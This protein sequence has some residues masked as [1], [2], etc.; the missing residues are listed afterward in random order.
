MCSVRLVLG[1]ERLGE[2]DDGALPPLRTLCRALDMRTHWSASEATFYIESPATGRNVA[3]V[4]EPSNLAVY[5]GAADQIVAMLKERLAQAGAQ[6]CDNPQE[7]HLTLRIAVG[8]HTAAGV[9]AT[10]P[11]STRQSLRTLAG[12]ITAEVA[13]EAQLADLG[14]KASLIGGRSLPAPWLQV[15][16][17]RPDQENAVRLQDPAVCQSVA[18]GIFGGLCRHWAG[19]VLTEICRYLPDS[20]PRFVADQAMPVFA[21]PLEPAPEL[22]PNRVPEPEQEPDREPEPLS[23][24]ERLPE[25]ESLS[26]PE[27]LPELEPMLLLAPQPEPELKRHPE[28]VPDQEPRLVLAPVP[29]TVSELPRPAPPPPPTPAKPAPAKP[30]P[31][32]KHRTKAPVLP[33]GLRFP[34][35]PVASTPLPAAFT[36]TPPLIE[37][38]RPPA[39][40][41]Q[42]PPALPQQPPAPP[43][44]APTPP[45]QTVPALSRSVVHMFQ[46]VGR[47]AQRVRRGSATV[48]SFRQ[49]PK[50]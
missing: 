23:E 41:Q 34:T 37:P 9:A 15:G 1:M 30:A 33:L 10:Y 2:V 36:P 48:S 38:Q 14:T 32:L 29:A 28:P 8:T 35:L 13:R 3:V 17:G 47:P 19:P 25:P 44:Q 7:A 43:Q 12:L 24:P 31:A 49:Q 20:Q 11:W 18:S 50:K 27:P 42:F 21:L 40:P 26:E 39:V 45:Q 16:I 22:A 5:A 46:W 4:A 6:V